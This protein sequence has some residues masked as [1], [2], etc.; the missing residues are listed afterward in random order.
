MNVNVVRVRTGERPERLLEDVPAHAAR[1]F[2]ARVGAA[3]IKT[4]GVVVV[5]ERDRLTL[6]APTAVST[7]YTISPFMGVS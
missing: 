7:V 2:L 6:D 1:A 4:P 3:H 5:L